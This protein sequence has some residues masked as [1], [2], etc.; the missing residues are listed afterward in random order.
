[1]KT[2]V[3]SMDIE[4]WYHLDYFNGLK[5]DKTYS[6]LDGINTYLEILSLHNIQSTFFVVS[7]IA[8]S[9]S[10]TLKEIINE[11][12]EISSHGSNHIRPASIPLS[13]FSNDL[14][15]SKRTLEE[16]IGKNIEGYRAPCFSINRQQLDIVQQAGYTY[17]SSRIDF[18]S[19]P[20]YETI[21]M[22]GY[23]LICPNIYR[24]KNFF[25]FQVTTNTFFGK[26]IPISGGGYLRILPW[27]ISKMLINPYLSH[28]EL[29]ILYIHPF[30]L[31][32]KE[33]P[34]FPSKTRWHNQLRF[35]IGRRNVQKKLSKLIKLLKN[36][37]YTFQTFSSLKSLLTQ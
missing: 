35:G 8:E 5:C 31:S 23:E 16:I 20:L 17:D 6:M 30:E 15:N 4:D 36:N 7:E 2:V 21:N 22:N 3:L 11:K 33:N 25:E 9:I 14:Y 13:S 24:N 10:H 19:H 32:L 28:G 27:V 26:N 37:G 18:D 1:M 29:Y 12:H 34:P